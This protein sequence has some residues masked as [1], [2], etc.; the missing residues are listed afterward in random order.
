MCKDIPLA[1]KPQHAIA[2]FAVL[3]RIQ[4]M[5]PQTAGMWIVRMQ[6]N[7]VTGNGQWLARGGRERHYAAQRVFIDQEI[8]RRERHP[9]FRHETAIF[10][11]IFGVQ[12]AV[13]RTFLATKILRR[14]QHKMVDLQSNREVSRILKLVI[15]IAPQVRHVPAHSQRSHRTQHP[16]GIEF[17]GVIGIIQVPMWGKIIVGDHRSF[18]HPTYC[19][20]RRSYCRRF[21]SQGGSCPVILYANAAMWSNGSGVGPSLCV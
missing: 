19:H 8:T 16:A 17:P 11:A 13:D 14:D 20:S 5:F 21:Y 6:V 1:G 10:K 4:A 12:L 3:Q 2:P 18:L 15:N 9:I 7:Q